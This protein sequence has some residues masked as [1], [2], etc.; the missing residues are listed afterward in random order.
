[1]K[2]FATYN[3][4]I[5]LATEMKPIIE[6]LRRFSAEAADQVERATISIVL[7]ISEGDRLYGKNPRKFFAIASGSTSEVLGALDLARA[8]NWP[9]DDTRARALLDR[10]RALLWGLVHPKRERG[11]GQ[12]RQEGRTDLTI[13]R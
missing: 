8:W 2:N 13:T 6:Q 9:I 4:A 1:M 7:N 3:V 5:E 10:Q 12:G 11:S